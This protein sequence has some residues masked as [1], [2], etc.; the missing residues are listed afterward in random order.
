MDRRTLLRA[1][2]E[3]SHGADARLDAA[4][5]RLK[6]ELSN[7]DGAEAG[8]RRLVE[9]MA[10]TLQGALLVRHAPAVVADALCAGPLAGRLGPAFG[11]L[12]RP[13][14]GGPASSTCHGG[15]SRRTR[16]PP[17]RRWRCPPVRPRPG[18]AILFP[19]FT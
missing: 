18:G 9:L 12:P 2:A 3:L 8:A 1:T 14:L 4:V 13:R 7:L 17:P 11:T 6:T 5:T 16:P 19:T 15:R 10:L